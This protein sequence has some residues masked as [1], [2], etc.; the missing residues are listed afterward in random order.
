MIAVHGLEFGYGSA[1]PIISDFEARFAAGSMSALV[2]RSGSG[3]ST[4]LY[5]IGMMLTPRSGSISILGQEAAG[6]RDYQRAELRARHV[7]F[8][9]QDALLDPARSV[10]DNVV[11]G[12]LYEPD[13]PLADLEARA[14]ELLAELEVEVEVERRPGQISGGQAQRVA[15]ARAFVGQPE[16]I[17]ADEPTGN[18][19]PETADVVWSILADRARAGS[20]VLI[21]THDHRRASTC[22]HV[23]RIH[24]DAER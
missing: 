2:G 14:R 22:D 20:T 5:L 9:F 11:E 12:G 18:L 8:V 23:V 15:L 19:D 6:L 3:K 4:L 16:I 10:L 21:A 7:G 17:L 24:R 1:P 13:E